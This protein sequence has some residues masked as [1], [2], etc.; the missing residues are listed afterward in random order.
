MKLHPAK[1]KKVFFWTALILSSLIASIV[2]AEIVAVV[3]ARFRGDSHIDFEDAF[4]DGGS[5]GKGGALKENFRAFMED[6]YGGRVR[7]AN[8]SSGF[9][10]DEEYSLQ[11]GHGVLRIM[12]LGDSFVAGYRV[13]QEDTFSYLLQQW[14]RNKGNLRAEILIAHEGGGGCPLSGLYYLMN[15]GV[16][17]TPHI[18]ILGITLGNDIAQAYIGLH[19]RGPYDLEVSPDS[20]RLTLR[21]GVK[22]PI[23]FRHGLEELE[24]PG[25]CFGSEPDAGKIGHGAFYSNAI[26]LIRRAVAGRSLAERPQ[27]IKS[28]YRSLNYRPDRLFDPTNGLGVYLKSPPAEMHEAY[29][30]L[31]R[32]LAAYTIFCRQQGILL[33]VTL[34]PQRFQVQPGDWKKTVEV[35]GLDEAAFDLMLPNKGIGDYCKANGIP[36]IDPTRDMA[37]IYEHEKRNLYLP[38]GDMHW[39]KLGHRAYFQAAQSSFAEIVEIALSKMSAKK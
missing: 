8:N 37:R 5:L 29:E 39:N 2:A 22:D 26:M 36:C 11:P 15:H 18:L 20:V 30:Q 35:Y 34:F 33:A 13:G 38:E 12:S 4:R 24:L 23:G 1:K 27:A 31:F 16:N 10:S 6:G 9:R 17:W 7:W 3:A 32:V 25:A 21:E 19:P 14:L 28:Y